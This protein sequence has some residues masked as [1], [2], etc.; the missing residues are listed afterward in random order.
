MGESQSKHAT[1]PIN[2]QAI[3]IIADEAVEKDFGT[4]ILKITPPH[5]RLDFE[6]AQQHDLP[7]IDILNSDGTLNELAGGD[8]VGMDRFSARKSV[9]KNF[10]KMATCSTRRSIKTTSDIQSGRAYPSNRG[11]PSNGFSNTRGWRK[12]RRRLR[13][14]MSN[15]SREMGKDRLALA[16]KHSGLVHQQATLVGAPDSGLVQKEPSV[17]T[18]PI[19]T[20]VRDRPVRSGEMGAGRRRFGYLGFFLALALATLGGRAK[21]KW[22]RRHSIIST[23][24][25]SRYGSRHHL[26]LGCPNDHGRARIQGKILQSRAKD[27]RRRNPRR[28]PFRH[29]YFTGIIRD[30]EGRKMSKSRA[31]HRTRST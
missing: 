2:P 27:S 1:R 21:R 7:M 28:I 31:I 13:T 8:F 15:S 17:R 6:I 20:H 5:D 26:L 14:V 12:Q 25:D 24:L 22:R 18:L 4:G 19:G 3:P 11:C 29:C 10:P 16:R 23:R 30:A 9:V